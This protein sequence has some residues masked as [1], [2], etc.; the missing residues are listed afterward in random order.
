MKL[1]EVPYVL[2][3]PQPARSLLLKY[4]LKKILGVKVSFAE[5]EANVILRVLAKSKGSLTEINAAE[6]KLNIPVAGINV[7]VTAR[8]YPSSDLGIL[9]Q[10]LGKN[11]YQPVIDLVRRKLNSNGE[12]RIVDA[13][14]NVGY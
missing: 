5:K 6:I 3:L 13:G 2:V 9:F 11:E 4:I 1:N 7:S 12:I 10:V 8:R 14:A